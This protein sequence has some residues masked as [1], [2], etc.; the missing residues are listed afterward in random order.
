MTGKLYIKTFGCQMNEYDSAKIADV[1]G[2]SHGLTPTPIPEEADVLLLN[3]CS[4]R[5]KAQEK[6]F[7]Q[8]GIWREWK[9]AKPTLVIES[10]ATVSVQAL[11]QGSAAPQPAPL[12]WPLGLVRRT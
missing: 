10:A 9:E 12:A 8:L 6:V 1:L 4:I 3:T 2:A 7:S 11:G 5:E